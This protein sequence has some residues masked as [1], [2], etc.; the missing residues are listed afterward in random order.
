MFS[1]FRAIGGSIYVPEQPAEMKVTWD[2][3]LPRLDLL[4]DSVNT[5]KDRTKLEV[6]VNHK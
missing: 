4:M 6:N 3:L 1:L 5:A 2:Q